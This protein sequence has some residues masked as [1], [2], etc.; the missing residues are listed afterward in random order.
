[1][2]NRVN[3][4]YSIYVDDLQDEL[5]RLVVR[6]VKSANVAS[7]SLQTWFKQ[8]KEDPEAL[9]SSEAASEIVRGS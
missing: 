9:I 3:L 4:Q 5:Y 8:I 2:K 1:M 7:R 6:G